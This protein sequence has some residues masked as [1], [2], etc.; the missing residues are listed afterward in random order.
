MCMRSSCSPRF[1]AIGC[2]CQSQLMRERAW[3]GAEPCSVSLKNTQSRAWEPS[4][5]STPIIKQLA[6]GALW[7]KEVPG[8]PVG[9]E[10][11]RGCSV[12]NHYTEKGSMT[13]LS[14]KNIYIYTFKTP[15]STPVWTRPKIT[16]VDIFCKCQWGNNKGLK[17]VK[18]GI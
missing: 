12:K 10:K 1:S 3:G 5:T 2:H 11:D 18:T 16:L 14:F 17:K 9:E 6:M 15:L 13:C 7:E 4:C 8:A